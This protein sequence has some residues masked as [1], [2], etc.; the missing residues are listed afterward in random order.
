M[1]YCN[2]MR[3]Y[4]LSDNKFI[5]E[6]IIRQFKQSKNIEIRKRILAIIINILIL[7][8]ENQDFNNIDF[9]IS[10]GEYISTIPD[11][12]FYKVALQFFINFVQYKLKNKQICLERCDDIIHLFHL[13]GMVEYASEL[14][15][16]KSRYK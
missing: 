16:F 11:L 4:S 14:N 2:S 9:F 8:I 10:S 1:L 13:S 3:F 5:S 15:K 7:S 6:K 12:L